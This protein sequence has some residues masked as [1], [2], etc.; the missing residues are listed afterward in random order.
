MLTNSMAI[1]L[2]DFY[3]ESITREIKRTEVKIIVDSLIEQ[4]C[5]L[6]FRHILMV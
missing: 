2:I 4:L 3:E 6:F 1:K 5:K